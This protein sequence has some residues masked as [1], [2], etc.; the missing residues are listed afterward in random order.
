M[1]L[2]ARGRCCRTSATDET[3]A[4]G[5]L[6]GKLAHT[7]HSF[8][9]LASPLLGGLL[10]EVAHLH[11]AENAFAL[12][13]LLESAERLVDIVI[14]DK[15]LHVDPVPS[16]FSVSDNPG[17]ANT[18]VFA[19]PND[20]TI[21]VADSSFATASPVG[22]AMLAIADCTDRVELPQSA[23]ISSGR[24]LQVERNRARL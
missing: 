16:R 9:L 19:Q 17:A 8:S 21:G 5:A 23:A 6:A 20:L 10:V 7:P 14:T 24:A 11:F 2:S 22:F 18:R 15:Y 1:D 13:L 12:H 3:F 4:L